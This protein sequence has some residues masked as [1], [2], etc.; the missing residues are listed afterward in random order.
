MKKNVLIIFISFFLCS[1][2]IQ[3]TV[4]AIDSD[5]TN[6]ILESQKDSLGI[7]DFINEA[8]VYTNDSFY[9]ISLSNVLN[10]ALTGKIEKK[11]IISSINRMLGTEIRDC[12]NSFATILVI[13]IIH[14]IFKSICENLGNNSTGKIA[15]Y[16][17]YILILTIIINNFS[18]IVVDTKSAIDN[19]VGMMNSLV[20]LFITLMLTTGSIVS[21]NI[22]QPIL[23]FA[24]AFVGNFISTFIIPLLLIGTS[25][26]VVSNLSDEIKID[27]LSKYFKSS[28]IWILGILLT[29]FVC[30]LS[31]EGTLSSG[32]DGLTA[33][34][35][36]AA[37]SS[38][39]PV[40]GKVLGDA[41][42]TVIGCASILK[43][44][45]GVLG[46]I[47]IIGIVAKPIIKLSL[48]CIIYYLASA[49]C[50]IIADKKIVKLL[51]QIGDTFKIL[52]AILFSVSLL[53]I[54]GIT[55]VIKITNSGLMY[56]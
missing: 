47:I 2:I 17:Q 42:D 11:G 48:L 52:L 34:T 9:N 54:V 22:V 37:V 45:V 25:L 10:E 24:I 27:K 20:P 12:L 13:V 41:V 30:L 39:I 3:N 46:I 26:S 31:I 56:R 50:E 29:I 23:L 53:F 6:T 40:V 4:F 18:E 1:C 21:A 36:K 38:F 43:N 8:E 19:L 51:E 35:A 5:A 44:A 32:V 7:S 33:K 15:Y 55:L 49:L 14:S 16:I 28:I